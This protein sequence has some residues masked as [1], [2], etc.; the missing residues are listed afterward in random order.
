MGNNYFTAETLLFL[1]EL[2]QNNSREWFQRQR[3]R[4]EAAV[5]EPA[6]AYIED[7]A[8]LLR[9]VSPH[10]PA[11]AK[12]TGG[13]LMR[14]QRDT[15]FSR[16]KA[17]YKLNVGIQFRHEMG[18]DVHAPGYYLHIQPGHCFIGV[19]IW[20]PNSRA[21][22]RIRQVMDRRPERWRA[23]RDDRAFVYTYNLGGESLQNPPRGYA[24]DHP[25]LEDL[26]RKDVIAD[27]T[28]SVEEALSPNL[29]E[30][31]VQN[32][33]AATAFISFLCEALEIP[34]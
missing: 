22:S 13:S 15:R 30:L 21:L 20:R 16:D 18:R 2:Q 5:R 8:P 17:P 19:G 4:Y 31:T 25:L 6:L 10:F 34:F 33:A 3:R 11:I 14:V 9:E 32:F 27:R 26:K 28:L 23:A 7:D 29:P 24:R 1:A 12:K